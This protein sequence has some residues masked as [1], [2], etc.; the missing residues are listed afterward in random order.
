VRSYF[1]AWLA[2]VW[3]GRGL[4]A[5]LLWPLSILHGAARALAVG[6]YRIGLRRAQ[7][8]GIPVVVIGNL[9]AGG[10][11]KTP[12]LIEVVR[13][14]RQRGWHPGVISRGYGGEARQA[15]LVTSGCTAAECGDEPVLIA[16]A[17]GAPV[18][19]GQDR[20]EA[21][22]LLRRSH[23]SCNVLVSDDGLQHRALARDVE[24][25]VIHQ[26][27]MGNG[28]LLP[29]GP[30]RDPPR[31]LRDVDAVVFNGPIQPVRI[32]SPF[33]RLSTSI[34][35]AFSLSRPEQRTLLSKLAREQA[36]GK[37]RLLAACGIGTPERFFTML[38]DQGLK[39]DTMPLPD[40]FSYR[41]NPFPANGVERIL[42]TEKDA[43]K[44]RLDRMLA[45]DERIWVVPLRAGLDARLLDLIEARLLDHKHGSAAA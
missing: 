25:A 42:I 44:C 41:H 20:V 29:A 14:L 8:V 15:R 5:R 45:R 6:V 18:A 37:M 3:Q 38:Q 33:F 21:A 16:A 13:G 12:T 7:N 28:W 9:Y 30:L 35:E 39:F 43:V 32:H 26:R 27:G 19:V 22:R 10:T 4:T 11:G 31:R 23:P 1:D 24:I 2:R 36:Q 40:H 34:D 17:T